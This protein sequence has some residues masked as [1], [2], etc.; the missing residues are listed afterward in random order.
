MP[1]KRTRPK[2][3]EIEIVYGDKSTAVL[4]PLEIDPNTLV[5]AAWGRF[6][7]PGVYPSRLMR[8][9]RQLAFY[10]PLANLSAANLQDGDALVCEF[11]YGQELETPSMLSVYRM[12]FQYD[13]ASRS[14]A[15]EFGHL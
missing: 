6:L 10:N 15:A 5:L 14:R 1:A 13:A 7:P 3:V 4:A 9:D 8:G 12:I 2:T 11:D